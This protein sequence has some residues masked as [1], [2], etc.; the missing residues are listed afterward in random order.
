M[1]GY[2]DMLA[3]QGGDVPSDLFLDRDEPTLCPALAPLESAIASAEFWLRRDGLKGAA[4]RLYDATCAADVAAL[5]LPLMERDGL[6]EGTDVA[7]AALWHAA[8]CADV[9]GAEVCS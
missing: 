6:R 4:A 5:V 8:V 9:A 2:G 7:L 3:R 1:S